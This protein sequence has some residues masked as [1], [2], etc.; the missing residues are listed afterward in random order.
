MW[1]VSTILSG[2]LS[3]MNEDANA[4]GSIF[5]S[6]NSRKVYAAKSL[7]FNVKD[8]K[9]AELFPDLVELYKTDKQIKLREKLANEG[10]LCVPDT[11]DDA[12]LLSFIK[13]GTIVLVIIIAIIIYLLMNINK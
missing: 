6:E 2:L 13:Y 10:V 12:V 4:V 8:K 5:D 7:G 9:F 1:S 3:F 11:F